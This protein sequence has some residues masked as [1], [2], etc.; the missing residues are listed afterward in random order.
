MM[1]EIQEIRATQS[2]AG[3]RS[4]PLNVA[5]Y[6]WLEHFYNPVVAQLQPL[7]GHDMT[8]AELYCQ[9]LEH[10]WFLSEQAQR[11]VGHQAATEDYLQRFGEKS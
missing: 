8:T 2:Q 9:I 3:N 5:A 4:T 1:N 7:A 6:Y 11:D 10:K